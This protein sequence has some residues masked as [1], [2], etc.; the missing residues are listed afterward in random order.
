MQ[1]NFIDHTGQTFGRLTVISRAENTKLGMARWHCTCECGGK[2]IVCGA[3]LRLDNGT[4]SCGCIWLSMVRSQNNGSKDPAFP[5]WQG[6]V[7]RTTNP[8]NKKFHVYGGAGIGIAPEWQFDFWAFREHVGPKPS[9][10]H[11]IDRIDGTKGYTPGNVRWATASEQHINRVT[12]RIV[13][14][15]G[16]SLPLITLARQHNMPP[17]LVWERI[18]K[19]SWSLHRA[20]TTPKR[21]YPEPSQA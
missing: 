14:Y 7:S 12:T 5:G 3:N 8:R 18:H 6:M 17:R 16:E 15:G 21:Y 13:E 4:R 1:Y 19:Q 20:L 9:T 10:K 11:S 2:A